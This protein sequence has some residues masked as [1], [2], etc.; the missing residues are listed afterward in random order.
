MRTPHR[1]VPRPVISKAGFTATRRTSSGAL[2]GTV[3]ITP[4]VRDNIAVKQVKAV[5]TAGSEKTALAASKSPWSMK[6]RPAART[7]SYP[8]TITATDAA[9]STRT[10]KTK[11]KVNN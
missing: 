2:R 8:V 4:T 11:V 7:G 9:G 3:T 1:P 5:I 10:C 6:W